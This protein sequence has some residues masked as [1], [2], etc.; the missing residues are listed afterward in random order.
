[1]I[2]TQLDGSN[3]S[4]RNSLVDDDAIAR[5]F[6]RREDLNPSNPANLASIIDAE[7]VFSG[8]YNWDYLVDWGPQF[9]PM[10]G[11]FA[12]IARLRDGDVRPKTQ[13]T[14]IV[15]QLPGGGAGSR[16]RQPPR[17]LPPP[18]IID[19]PPRGTAPAAG[20][21]TIAASAQHLYS[22]TPSNRSFASSTRSHAPSGSWSRPSAAPSGTAPA[23]RGGGKIPRRSPI[24]LDCFERGPV[25]PS[26]LPNMLP[27]DNTRSPIE[28]NSHIPSDVLNH[29]RPFVVHGTSSIPPH[30]TSVQMHLN[31]ASSLSSDQEIHI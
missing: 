14:Q 6:G 12:E 13:P 9:L 23:A 19:T 27:L 2:Y 16:R 15:P 22:R 28:M 4:D 3:S 21:T 10:A 26:F 20:Q 25:A 17:T 24:R 30:G 18:L 11:L 5:S 7:E 8:S 31:D 29:H 1:M